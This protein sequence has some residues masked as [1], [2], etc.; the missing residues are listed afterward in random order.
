M[1]TEGLRLSDG[2]SEAH[3]EDGKGPGMGGHSRERR[4]P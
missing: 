4:G 3:R 2:H 1:E